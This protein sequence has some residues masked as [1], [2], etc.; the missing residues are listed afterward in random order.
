MTLLE[1]KLMSAL[2]EVLWVVEGKNLSEKEELAVE[3]AVK[4][5]TEASEQCDECVDY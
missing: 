2:A 1:K 5:L 3:E 4:V